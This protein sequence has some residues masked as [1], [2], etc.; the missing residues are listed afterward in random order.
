[1]LAAEQAAV[2]EALIKALRRKR[3][4]DASGVAAGERFDTA[5]KAVSDAAEDLVDP[6]NETLRGAAGSVESLQLATPEDWAQVVWSLNF[7]LKTADLEPIDFQLHGS[8]NQSQAMHQML[9]FLDTRFAASFGWHQ[10]TIWALEEPESFLHADLKNE[11]IAFLDDRTQGDRFQAILTTHDLVVAAGGDERQWI[12]AVSGDTQAESVTPAEL[13]DR[14]ISQG[15][16]AFVHPLHLSA[17]KPTLL[18]EG[19]SDV[20][21]VEEAYRRA[22]R[23]NPWEIR[24]LG[25]IE[26]DTTGGKEGIRRY[27]KANQAALRARPSRSPVIVV[28]DWEVSE[29]EVNGLNELISTQHPWSSAT[30]W[31][32]DRSNPDLAD[33]WVG[34]ERFLATPLVETTATANPDAGMTRTVGENPRWE[35][36]PQR[37][38]VAKKLLLAECGNRDLRDDLSFIIDLLDWLDGR[39]PR[40]GTAQPIPA[41]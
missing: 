26:R 5:L 37:K 6:I 22:A 23:A 15:V 1:V 2:Q 3:A 31:P 36:A 20:W 19:P 29:G 7:R 39:L 30:R 9:Y 11:L 40:S 41:L 25:M 27:L 13:A 28:L 4:K 8:G 14:S 21:Y 18:L 35:L 38:D 32:V 17:M 33:S 24:H 12:Y 16:S 34:I 10:A